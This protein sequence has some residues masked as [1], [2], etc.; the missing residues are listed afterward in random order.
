MLQ[1]GGRER[2][3]YKILVKWEFH[4]IKGLPYKRFSVVM[5]S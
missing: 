1:R 2:S 4:A 5:K 3:I